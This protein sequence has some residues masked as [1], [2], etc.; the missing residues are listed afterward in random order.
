VVEEEA[1]CQ[2]EDGISYIPLKLILHLTNVNVYVGSHPKHIRPS[3]S[4]CEDGD[5]SPN[6]GN[7][8]LIESDPTTL[9]YTYVGDKIFK[10]R[11][12]API[13]S[14][15]SPIGCNDVPYSFAIDSESNIY[16]TIENVVFNKSMKGE[17]PSPKRDDESDRDDNHYEWYYKSRVSSSEFE[18]LSEYTI[19]HRGV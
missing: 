18:A 2:E 14:F 12:L 9:E 17:H 5:A 8:I 19:L 1:V 6:K 10:F 3:S 15:T 16:L 13:V 4:S 7:S 11:A